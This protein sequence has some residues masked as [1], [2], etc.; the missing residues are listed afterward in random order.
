MKKNI[1]FLGDLV[2]QGTED[3]TSSIW[4]SFLGVTKSYDAELC[5]NLENPIFDDA[6]SAVKEKITLKSIKSTLSHLIKLDPYLINLANNHINDF[7]NQGSEGT[8]K[9]LKEK[10]LN[11]FG[12]GLTKEIDN[13]LFFDKDRK[14]VHLAFVTRSCDQTGSKLFATECFIGPSETCLFRVKEVKAKYPECKL[15]VH[16]HWGVEDVY[17]PEPEKIEL[18]HKIVDA[19]ADLIIGTHPHI[20]Q[21]LEIYN[22]KHIFYSLGNFYFP[23][24]KYAIGKNELIRTAISHQRKG[25]IPIVNFDGPEITIVKLL[26]VCVDRGGGVISCREINSLS[27]L[28]FFSDNAW[29]SYYKKEMLKLK[30]VQAI[31]D[32]SIIIRKIIKIFNGNEA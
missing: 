32:P 5:L 20:I 8:I 9:N 30:L 2:L 21:P 23:D 28:K 22:G 14:I 11:C 25:I 19:G 12:V 15:V 29:I 27:P 3:I 24:I 17:Y 10:G 31:K 18:G 26:Q 6:I 7:G 16:I 4:D 1:A 13:N